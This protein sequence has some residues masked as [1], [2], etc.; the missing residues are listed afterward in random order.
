M[1][2]RGDP[3]VLRLVV[4][5]L[6]SLARMNQTEFGRVC[7]LT[8]AKVSSYESGEVAAPEDALRRMAKAAQIDE[9]VVALFRQ[10]LGEMLTAVSQGGAIHPPES[11]WRGEAIGAVLAPYLLELQRA[12]PPLPA[13][14]DARREA[15]WIWTALERFPVRERAKLISM[16]LRVSAVGL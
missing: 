9:S 4:I 12:K 16:A 8:Q 3:E 13:P 1:A 2:K 14:E 7:R 11:V 5:V 6:R 15:D 10:F